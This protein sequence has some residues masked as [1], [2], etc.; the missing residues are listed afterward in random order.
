MFVTIKDKIY[1]PKELFSSKELEALLREFTY[2]NP[3]HG[4]NVRLHI[5]NANTPT[6]VETYINF[7]KD[8]IALLRGSYNKFIDFCKCYDKK[9]RVIRNFSEGYDIDFSLCSHIDL[10]SQQNTIIETLLNHGG[11]L[12]EASPGIGK[13]ISILGFIEKT[14]KSTLI[15]VDKF[16]LQNQWIEEFTNKTEGNYSLGIIN[17]DT[18]TLGDV[19]VGIINS[20]FNMFTEDPSFVEQYGAVVIDEC[21]KIPAHMFT[22]VLSNFPCKYQIGVTGTPKRQD[23]KHFILFDLLGEPLCVIKSEEVKH[24]VTDFDYE[25]INTNI[26][27]TVPMKKVPPYIKRNNPDAKSTTDSTKL[28]GI[29]AEHVERN[30]IILSDVESVIQAGRHPMIIVDRIVH[31]EY[32]YDKLSE[33]YDGV[34]LIGKTSKKVDLEDLRVNEGNQFLI[35]NSKIA[36]EAL[37]VPYLTDVF[38]PCP[39][40]NI[41]KL[42]QQIGRIRRVHSSKEGIVPKVWDYVDNLAYSLDEEDPNIKIYRLTWSAKERKRLYESL[43]KAYRT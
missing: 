21:H 38:L 19:T 9:F 30:S 28:L 2:A 3:D 42:E 29:L 1:V 18:K 34:L 23:K 5:S 11:G 20:V 7:D 10:E 41:F 37:D 25:Q 35:A 31:A 14:K 24:R 32:L 39:T 43:Q 13:T 17:G 15:L 26:D 40:S 33:K 6:T 12:I 36:S 8:T 22:T 16:S 4:R 27:F